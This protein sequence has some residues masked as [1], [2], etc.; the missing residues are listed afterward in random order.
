A[1]KP[2]DGTNAEVTRLATPP[3]HLPTPA[4]LLRNVTEGVRSS[5]GPMT[6]GVRGHRNMPS[7]RYMPEA[8]RLEVIDYVKG[9]NRGFWERREIK[10]IA[11]PAAPPVTI[12]R[13]SRGKQLYA[14]A[15][16]LACHGE[17]G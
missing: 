2:R 14:D 6:I 7:F 4:D 1:P 12:E 3:G 17:R 5:G 10:T 15:E 16:C 13:L 11:M 9:V 8:Q